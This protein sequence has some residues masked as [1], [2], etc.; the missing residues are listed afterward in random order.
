[1]TGDVSQIHWLASNGVEV[2][3]ARRAALELEM[4]PLTIKTAPKTTCVSITTK[5]NTIAIR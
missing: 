5:R 4:E 1:M 2:N 3:C